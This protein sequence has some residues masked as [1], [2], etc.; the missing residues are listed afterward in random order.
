MIK[1]S[2]SG[3][4]ASALRSLYPKIEP[5]NHFYIPVGDGHELY[6][7]ECGRVDGIPA[8]F[9]HGGPGAGCETYHRQLFDPDRYRI[10]LFDQRGAGRSRPYANLEENNTQ[11]LVQDM[12]LIRRHLNIER[13]LVFGGSW[14]STLGL[15]YAEV[16][17]EHVSALV[18]R[19]IFLGREKEIEW[20]YQKGASFIY[21]DYWQDYLAPVPESER[22][23]M[24]NAYYGQL[25]SE[26]KTTRE[27]AAQAWA[28]WEGRTAT[29][30]GRQEVVDHFGDLSVAVSLA[31]IECHYFMN[32]NFLTDNQLIREVDRIRH[33]PAVIIQG[34]YDMVCP[35]ESAWELHEAWPEAEFKVIADAGHAASEAGIST[36][37]I[38]ATDRFAKLIAAKG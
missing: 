4:S 16:Y 35:M 11:A 1:H 25:T 9:V 2:S 19:G 21:P 31:R 20:L 13:W 26:D 24:V 36:A 37:L 30:M 14:G 18:L 15:A 10:I 7:E 6:V 27:R 29:L 38:E 3:Q 32:N 33:I 12:E 22:H 23:E 34:R 17:P 28:T 8:V 5:F